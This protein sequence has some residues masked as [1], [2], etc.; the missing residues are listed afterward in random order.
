MTKC[1]VLGEVP[2]E[3]RVKNPIEFTSCLDAHQTP[4]AITHGP[5]DWDV[6]GLVT[7][8]YKSSGLDIMLASD[9]GDD[10]DV[11][12]ALYFGHWNDGVVGKEA[13]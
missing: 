13:K 12:C 10:G 5:Q 7:R 2:G 8:N 11:E 4:R 3:K 1:I 9:Y 6:V